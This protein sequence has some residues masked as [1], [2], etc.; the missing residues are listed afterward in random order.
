MNISTFSP[1]LALLF[2]CALLWI[3][4]DIHFYNLTKVQKWLIPLLVLIL[5][6]FNHILR[7]HLGSA[8]YGNLIILTMHLPYFLLF[9]H[10]TKCGF[11]K[12]CF[13]LLSAV[14]F[15]APT[16][17]IGNIVKQCFIDSALWM[18]LSNLIS[19]CLVL[20]L[21]QFVFRQGFNYLLKHGEPR[22]LLRFFVVPLLYYVYVFAVMNLDFSVLSSP[23]GYMIRVLPTLYVFVF[24]FLFLHN[25]KELDEKRNLETAQAALSQQLESAKGQLLLLN[26]SQEQTATYRHDMRH[27]LAVISNFLSAGNPHQAEEYIKKVQADVETITIQ[28]FCENELVNLLCSSFFH[29]AEQD[30]IRL[31][32]KTTLPEQISISDTELCSI[33]SNGLENAL[34]AVS[35]LEAD[36]KWIEFYSNIQANKLLIE[37][38]NPYLGKIVMRDGL[39]VANWEGHGYG[40]R[41]IRSIVEQNRGMCVFEPDN[42]IFTLRIVIPVS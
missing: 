29:K 5:A 32:I 42:G 18:L 28:R 36:L 7:L 25:Y 3:L 31:T 22:F 8:V 19:Y 30:H 33:L 39:P 12:M 16:V 4:M 10:I 6:V 27:H 26:K 40:C 37:I 34:Y 9:L 11:V 24:Y 20:L 23:G 14:V 41:S 17:F 1:A 38:K 13:V 15:S 2:V 21:A 35:E